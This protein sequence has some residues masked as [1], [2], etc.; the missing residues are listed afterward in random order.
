MK[1]CKKCGN[2]C[3][4]DDNFCTKCGTKL[5]SICPH[6]WLK[7]GEEYSCGKPNCPGYSLFRLEKSQQELQGDNSAIFYR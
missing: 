5:D 1:E 6:C 4:S 7:H 2:I 3:E